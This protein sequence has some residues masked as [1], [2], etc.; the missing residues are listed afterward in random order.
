MSDPKGNG[1]F[2]PI[3]GTGMPGPRPKPGDAWQMVLPVPEEAPKPP[4]Q[5]FSNGKPSG[6]WPYR[7]V[8]GKMLGF[9]CR[10]ETSKGKDIRPLTF[11]Q[12]ATTG[13][14]AWHW[15]S[16][17]V[18]R[19]LY[20]LERLAQ[21]TAAPVLVVEGE[22]CADAAP[23]LL[24]DYVAVTSPGGSK[25][26]A[27]ADWSPLKYREI[28]IWPD[29]DA[30]GKD[31]ADKV[32]KLAREAGAASIRIIEVSSG[33]PDGW[34][35][36]DA[37]RDNWTENQAKAL[38]DTASF[39]KA[40]P[41]VEDAEGGVDKG[42]NFEG[43]RRKAKAANALDMI[44]DCEF[45][46]DKRNVA[47]ASFPFRGRLE[48]GKVRDGLFRTYLANLYYAATGGALSVQAEEEV[49]RTV[50]A[51]AVATGECHSPYRR[52]AFC[53]NEIHVDLCDDKGHAVRIGRDGWSV[54]TDS[55]VKFLRY[56][57][58]LPLP[59]PDE[60]NEPSIDVLRAYCNT[61][62]D[63][64]FMMAVAWIMGAFSPKGPYPILAVSGEMGSGKSYFTEMIA[65]IVD[66]GSGKRTSA[67]KDERDL[68][69]MA[70]HQHTMLFDNLSG[71][72]RSMSDNLCRLSTG[73]A[74]A[75]RKL[76][77]DD[78]MILL[79]A[80]RPV[81]I[82]GIPD[83]SKQG[84]LADRSIPLQLK[85]LEGAGRV[86]EEE[87]NIRLQ[88]DLPEILAALFTGISAGL[89]NRDAV[90]L[91]N[92]PRMADFAQWVEACAPGLGWEPG[93]FLEAYRENRE[94][95][96]A[97][98]FE[99]DAVAP[100]LKDWMDLEHPDGW[101]GKPANLYSL[102]CAFVTETKKKEPGWPKSPAGIGAAMKRIAP[103][104]R[105]NGYDITSGKSGERYISIQPIR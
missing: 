39:E 54:L 68:I 102:L 6:L 48:H 78:A 8:A 7:D 15:K 24:A 44:K 33:R 31:Y 55:P 103:I 79:E 83:L 13:V 66:P 2:A 81:V 59:L 23:S 82:N 93:E 10:F 76:H 77:S 36:A 21:N 70:Q 99:S 26:A 38:I 25:A 58:S 72:A 98:S 65:S 86:T 96:Y 50:A 89:R 67:P 80:Q 69:I 97:I 85:T 92:P 46:R 5:H 4:T 19:P 56:E 52:V 71:I 74:I 43:R 62:T 41:L 11:W 95:A 1:A 47:Y 87:L 18:P 42:E 51:R 100:S 90:K 104:M 27:K 73:G 14:C 34:D 3:A 37:I 35:I 30:P 45:W 9:V 29:N 22:K 12:N 61:E 57:G 32:A 64:D 53:G 91:E 49:L 17:P 20:G 28:V 63:Q 94:S 88:A 60:D 40:P 16:W 75:S 84:D 101:K 105:K